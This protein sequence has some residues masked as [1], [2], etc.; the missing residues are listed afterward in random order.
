M[1]W[2]CHIIF[3]TLAYHNE[4][5]YINDPFTM[6]TFDLKAKFD[7]H[8]T[9]FWVW[10]TTFLSYDINILYLAHECLHGK[11]YHIHWWLL[12][13]LCLNIEITFLPWIDRLCYFIQAYQIWHMGVS[14]WDNMLCTFMTSVWPLDL[15]DLYVGGRGVLSEFYLQISYCF[16]FFYCIK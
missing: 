3:G 10:V 15:Y 13:D 4:K 11:I 5:M 9:W 2:H 12:S 6:L 14:P 7:G 1:L 16:A 8:L